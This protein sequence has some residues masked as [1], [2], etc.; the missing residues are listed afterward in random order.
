MGIV[1]CAVNPFQAVE[2]TRRSESKG[3]YRGS[4]SAKIIRLSA[5][6]KRRSSPFCL[7]SQ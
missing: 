1:L 3:R 2:I 6:E 5:F 7:Y 4:V